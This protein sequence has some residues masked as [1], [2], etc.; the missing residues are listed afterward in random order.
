MRRR[1]FIGLVGGAA[2]WPI[3][4]RGQPSGRIPVVGV[5]WAYPDAEDRL[6]FLKGL[7]DLGYIPGKT[8]MLEERYA[9]GAPE[10]LDALAIELIGLNVDVLVSQAGKPTLALHRATSTIPIFFV[11]VD[12]VLQG[13]T[14]SLSKLGGNMSGFSQIAADTSAKRL[15]LLQKTTPA[16]SRVALLSDPTNMGAS[17]E[18]SQ[19]SSAANELGLSFEVFDASTGSEIDQAFQK[20]QEQQLQ[21]ALAFSAN[22]FSSERKRIAALG[23]RHRLAVMGPSK[24]FVEAGSL[25]SYGVDFPSLWYG[26]AYFVDR[27]LKGERVGDIPVQQHKFY[28]CLNLRTAKALGIEVAPATRALADEV[29][30]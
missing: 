22:F 27:I 4:V 1:E 29:I 6:S 25:L 5:F 30:E 3:A 16:V 28:F 8:F 20:M 24:Y 14:S 18:L 2:V 9:N 7:A 11:G 15:Q 26:S 17:Y 23:L 13:W 12:P 10:R 21:A 19:L